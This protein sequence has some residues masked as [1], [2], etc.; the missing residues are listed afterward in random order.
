MLQN[1]QISD[2][3]VIEEVI[4]ANGRHLFSQINALNET[5][6][7]GVRMQIALYAGTHRRD[8]F[9][10]LFVELPEATLIGSRRFACDVFVNSFRNAES[11]RSF[12][13]NDMMPYLVVTSTE[14][15]SGHLI[16][17]KWNHVFSL[18]KIEFFFNLLEYRKNAVNQIEK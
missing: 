15:Q 5:S 18:N 13:R 11:T 9:A 4:S 6:Q 10:G 1:I 17:R 14:T 3:D 2:F 12:G 7:D 8:F 16:K